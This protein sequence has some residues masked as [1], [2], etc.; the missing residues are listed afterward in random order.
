M[1]NGHYPHY[2]TAAYSPRSAPAPYYAPYPYPSYPAPAAPPACLE[3][4]PRAYAA[5]AADAYLH[6]HHHHH[7]HLASP[8]TYPAMYIARSP[9]WAPSPALSDVPKAP[10]PCSCGCAT[11][12]GI[13][14]P[15]VAAYLPTPGTPV[16]HDMAAAVPRAPAAELIDP[17]VF[18][19]DDEFDETELSSLAATVSPLLLPQPAAHAPSPVPAAVRYAPPRPRLQLLRDLVDATS[20]SGGSSGDASDDEFVEGDDVEVASASAWSPKT[21]AVASCAPAPQLVSVPPPPSSA[22]LDTASTAASVPVDPTPVSRKRKR[23]TTAPS[24]PTSSPKSFPCLAPGCTKVFTT[25]GHLHRH[26]KCVHANERPFACPLPGCRARF[27]RNDNRWQHYKTHFAPRRAFRYASV[28][29]TAALAAAHAAAAKAAADAGEA[30]P[31]DVERA[32]KR[33]RVAAQQEQMEG[34]EA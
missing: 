18:D 16:M 12:T 32:V 24:S 5:E 1:D 20:S 10:V 9:Q 21:P 31:E 7:A 15:P 6:H 23:S 13:P 29:T 3:P 27:S 33:A 17:P 26:E 34:A 30:V 19:D 4:T 25:S 22:L 28:R 2:P 14:A 11:T 8:P